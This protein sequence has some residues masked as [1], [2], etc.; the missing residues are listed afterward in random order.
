MDSPL[1][2]DAKPAPKYGGI[3]S[4][5]GSAI[6]S[7]AGS[8]K[9]GGIGSSGSSGSSDSWGQKSNL[10]NKQQMR[11]P[12]L[13]RIDSVVSNEGDSNSFTSPKRSLIKGKVKSKDQLM[14]EAMVATAKVAAMPSSPTAGSPGPAGPGPASPTSPPGSGRQR[15]SSFSFG[16]G[17]SIS[18]MLGSGNFS[19]GKLV[20]SGKFGVGVGLPMV[21]PGGPE[22]LMR[23]DASSDKPSSR[24]FSIGSNN[25]SRRSSHASFTTGGVGSSSGGS[26]EELGEHCPIWNT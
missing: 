1:T 22:L 12:A 17:S 20:G 25:T 8:G 19:S 5:A 2:D 11:P 10:R 6:S 26:G 24:R 7:S 14:A 15:K 4:S 3:N 9:H 23:S 18:G 16:G 21:S 13:A